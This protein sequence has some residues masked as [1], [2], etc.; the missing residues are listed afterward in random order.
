MKRMFART[1]VAILLAGS[2][3]AGSYNENFEAYS[4]GATSLSNGATLSWSAAGVTSVVTNPV[5]ELQFT[6]ADVNNTRAALLLPD[7]DP[8]LWQLHERRRG[9]LP[10]SRQFGR[11]RPRC[12]QRGAG[13][14]VRHGAR[15]ERAHRDELQPR[16]AVAGERRVP[17]HGGEP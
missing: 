4:S 8:G 14:R 11:Q 5:K 9:L 2:A 7:L 17:R 6:R 15:R 10:E 1:L 3:Y 13:H 16:H 12:D